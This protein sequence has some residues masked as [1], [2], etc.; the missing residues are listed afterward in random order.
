MKKLLITAAAGLACVGAFG[1]G[2]LNFL[3]NTD[4]LVYFT[5]SASGMAPADAAATFINPVSGTP[6]SVLGSTLATD[7]SIAALAGNQTF[8]A[9]LYG[10]TSA[11]SLVLQT[12]TTIDSW[13][14]G[15]PGGIVAVNTSF[16]GP[17]GTA[18]LP[19]G[20]A[21]FFQVVVANSALGN[22]DPVTGGLWN[23]GFYA[24]SS[25]VFQAT[26]V[27]LLANIYSPGAPVSST[28]APGTFAAL[29]DLTDAALNPGF[30]LGGVQV[31]FG[32]TVTPEP[33]TFALA[34]LGLA[35]L[36]VLRRRNS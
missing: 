29:T 19:A 16:N 7:G 35:A 14:D 17:R 1:Q 5:T 18:S 6:S 8:T 21:A 15:N 31:S 30:G 25:A 12:T 20:T 9:Y 11:G 13:G 4:N 32:A 23:A 34:G 27:S 33:G 3:N 22:T 28:W 26:P 2:T 24:G 36:L 10:G